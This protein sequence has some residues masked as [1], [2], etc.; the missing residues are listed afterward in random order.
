VGVLA[1]GVLALAVVGSRLGVSYRTSLSGCARE[2]G[3][4]GASGLYRWAGRI[5]IPVRL[6]DVPLWEEAPALKGHQGHCIVTMGDGSWSPMGEEPTP[7]NWHAVRNWISRGNTLIVVTDKP[8]DLPGAFR[9]DLLHSALGEAGGASSSKPAPALF[10]GS[11]DSRPETARTPVDTGGAL[12]VERDGPRWTVSK[13]QAPG[14]GAAGTPAPPPPPENDPT[15][16]QLAGDARGGVLFRIPVGLGA[17]YLL[18]DAFAWTNAGLDQGDNARVLADVLRREIRGGDL[19][20]DEYRHGHGRSESFLA[21]FLNSPGSSGFMWLAATWCLLYVYG[22]NVRLRPVEPYVEP[23]RRT[24]QEA[25]D[26]VA[27]LYERAR[28][29][30]LVVEAVARRLRQLA[31]SSAERPAVVEELLEKAEDYTRKEER[32]ASPSA[33]IRLVRELIQLRKRIYGTR[34]VS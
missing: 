9:T 12:M 18:L 21:Y 11:V 7:V 25:I 24:A 28:A 6:L 30:P 5:G 17:V 32:P 27:Q 3:T 29:A 20:F 2:N 19:A 34:T 33:A 13:N 22:R 31:R 23:E 16:W 10:Q 26:A 15:R 1:L 4:G 14:A 8:A